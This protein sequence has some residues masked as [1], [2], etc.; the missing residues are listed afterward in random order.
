MMRWVHL[1]TVAA[2]ALLPAHVGAIPGAFG[3]TLRAPVGGGGGTPGSWVTAGVAY[4]IDSGPTLDLNGDYTMCGWFK[5]HADNLD[6][7]QHCHFFI[8]SDGGDFEKLT[9]QNDL[10]VLFSLPTATIDSDPAGYT[11]DTWI[12]LCMRRSGTTLELV[13]D[14]TEVFQ[15]AADDAGR[16]STDLIRIGTADGQAFRGKMAHARAWQSVLTDGQ[17]ATEMASGTAVVTSALN[18]DL[19]TLEADGPGH[20]DSG[21]ANHFT[22]TGASFTF[23]ADT[24]L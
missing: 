11:V 1:V 10:G 13:A 6:G 19:T 14:G 22:E 15:I 21:N 3:P 4:L 7:G 9:N 23:D 24:P 2:L 17:I 12:H 16:N 5:P 8:V 18:F 20:D